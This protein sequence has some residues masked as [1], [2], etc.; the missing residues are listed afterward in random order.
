MASENGTVLVTNEGGVRTITLNRP[1]V[2]NAFNLELSTALNRAIAEVAGDEAVRC[3]VITGAGRAFCAGQDLIELSESYRGDTPIE[4]G[5]RLRDNYNPAFAG[6][7][8]ME[9]PVVASVNG[10][11]AGAGCSLALVCD[12]R[13]AGDSASFIEAFINVGL[14]PD[15]TSTYMLPRLVGV[16]RAMELAFTGRKVEAAEALRIGLVNQVVPDGRLSAETMALAQRLA[17]QPTRAIGLTK[18][19]LNAAWTAG[20]DAQL[21]LE[22]G[23]QAVAV[24]THDHQEGLH[25]FLEKRRPEFQGR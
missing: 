2:L 20:V 1:K 25:A 15:C 23:L 9:K 18:R 12:L 6:I 17:A 3:V 14:V 21:D 8:A 13:I 4:L 24:R 22:A 5:Q 11:A 7:R 19:A 10:V 16:S